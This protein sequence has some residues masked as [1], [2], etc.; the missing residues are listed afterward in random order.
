MQIDVQAEIEKTRE[1]IEES[2]KM[3][4]RLRMLYRELE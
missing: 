2:R 3:R 4:E 1:L